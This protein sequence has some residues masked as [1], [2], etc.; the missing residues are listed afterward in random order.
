M[1]EI[2]LLIRIVLACV[3]ALA[4]IGKLLDPAGSAKAV[5]DFG[6]PESMAVPLSYALPAAE[7]VTAAFLLFISSSWF[8]AIGA[9]ILLATFVGGMLWQYS[10]GKSPECHC[11]G[12]MH[13]EPVSPKSIARNVV[14][15][16]LALL[17]VVAGRGL[18][19]LPLASSSEGMVQTLLLLG[20]AIAAVTALSMLM[21]VLDSQREMSRKIELLELLSTADFPRERQDAGNPEDG[22]PLGGLFP[23][24]ELDGRSNLRFTLGRLLQ[25]GRPILFFF[26]GPNCSPCK[27]LMPEITAWASRLEGKAE[28]VLMTS[29]NEQENRDKLDIADGIT[30]LFDIDRSVA[31]SVYAKW[32]PSAILVRP[33]GRVASHVAV[34]DGAIRTLVEKVEKAD[35]RD[36]LLYITNGDPESQTKIGEPIPDFALATVQGET[37]ASK[38]LQGHPTLAVFWSTTCPHCVAM[39]SDLKDWDLKKGANEPNLVV[40]S[41]GDEAAHTEVGLA[42]PI[43]LESGYKTAI[44]LG[45]LGTPSAILI[46]ENGM[47]ASET[48]IGARNIWSLVRKR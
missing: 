42:S 20:L 4:G 38:D 8:G 10:Q 27:A 40:F 46:D 47:I 7:I 22:I 15:L 41:E 37:I 48:A 17:L 12:Q 5:K 33:D 36:R 11:F 18:Q 28:V 1:E 14:L 21:R 19:G 25:A 6:V 13:S 31:Q 24:F 45:M 3:F 23:D 30:L 44:G 26:V 32:T 34:G 39:M 9:S 2:L 29:G 43:V 35:A 16:S